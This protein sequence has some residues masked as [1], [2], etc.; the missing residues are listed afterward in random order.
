MKNFTKMKWCGY[1]ALCFAVT[2]SAAIELKRPIN[3]DINKPNRVEKPLPKLTTTK[4][5]LKEFVVPA[6]LAW[7]EAKK[8]GFE[9]YPEGARGRKDGVDVWGVSYFRDQQNRIQQAPNTARYSS[10][11]NME[12]GTLI[13]HN[14]WDLTQAGVISSYARFHLFGGKRLKSRW[15]VRSIEISGSHSI[16]RR[17]SA[18]S[19]SAHYVVQV[20]I[21]RGVKIPGLT[22]FK[23]IVLIGPENQN[24]REAFKR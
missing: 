19:T 12:M 13:N 14:F 10:G 16:F 18:N 6:A 5:R 2:T 4:V 11:I 9:F 22:T 23:K 21:R 1:L 8:Q 7:A 17:P 20:D 24:W 15:S 3:P